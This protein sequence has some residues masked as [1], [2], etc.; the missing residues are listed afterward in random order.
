MGVMIYLAALSFQVPA[1][2]LQPVVTRRLISF[3]LAPLSS[4]SSNGCWGWIQRLGNLDRQFRK[5]PIQILM[6]ARAARETIND[7]N[8]SNHCGT[9]YIRT[10]A[11]GPFSPPMIVKNAVAFVRTTTAFVRVSKSSFRR[12]SFA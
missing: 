3:D 7:I 2:A 6:S 4:K 11:T 1:P 9:S 12:R 8:Q 10:D 5:P